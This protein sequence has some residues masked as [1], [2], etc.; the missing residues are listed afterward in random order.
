MEKKLL[1]LQGVLDYRDLN[2]RYPRNTGNYF[3]ITIEKTQ[4][5]SFFESDSMPVNAS[6]RRGITSPFE[7][8]TLRGATI[9]RTQGAQ[10]CRSTIVLSASTAPQ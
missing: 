6:E 5:N 10:K 1:L 7:L 4:C 3:R 2:Y 8:P 9:D